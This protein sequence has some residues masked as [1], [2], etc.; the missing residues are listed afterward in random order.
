MQKPPISDSASPRVQFI[1]HAGQKRAISNPRTAALSL[2]LYPKNASEREEE[3]IDTKKR[4]R[5]NRIFVLTLK[6]L[7]CV[8]T[9]KKGFD[10][11]WLFVVSY[12]FFFFFVARRIDNSRL[13][14]QNER[15]SS[16]LRAQTAL[17]AAVP[18]FDCTDA[19]ALIK[20]L[21]RTELHFPLSLS[22]SSPLSGF[23]I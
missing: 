4:R 21:C 10:S 14:L 19:A 17:F 13:Y 16:E 23:D 20:T 3:Y 18:R 22:A 8:Y 12:F 11:C 9:R 5:A 2:S 7:L 1:H 15:S 6:R